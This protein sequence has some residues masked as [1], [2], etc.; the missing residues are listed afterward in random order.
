MRFEQVVLCIR[1]FRW[2]AKLEF[3]KH[4]KPEFAVFHCLC[5]FC[6][7]FSFYLQ[8]VSFLQS[9]PCVFFFWVDFFFFFTRFLRLQRLAVLQPRMVA[10]AAVPGKRLHSP[11][12]KNQRGNFPLS[13]FLKKNTST[14]RSSCRAHSEKPRQTVRV[15]YCN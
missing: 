7:V 12:M 5:C 14:G 8:G 4:C 2:L 3:C 6:S 13:V 10:A 15:L 11:K 1:L 9:Y